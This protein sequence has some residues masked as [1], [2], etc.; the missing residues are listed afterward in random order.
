MA[1]VEW[2]SR[3]APL[4]EIILYFG[5]LVAISIDLA[6]VFPNKPS[7]K[8]TLTSGHFRTINCVYTCTN[9]SNIAFT[10]AFIKASVFV[11][12]FV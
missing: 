2:S 5:V 11:F 3:R 10:F 9:Y 4:D 6:N 8:G 1:N 7:G 12:L